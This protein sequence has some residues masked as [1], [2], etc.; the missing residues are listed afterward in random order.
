MDYSEKRKLVMETHKDGKDVKIDGWPKRLDRSTRNSY[1]LI[2]T[3]YSENLFPEFWKLLTI[4]E[5]LV[6]LKR[7][8]EDQT[9]MYVRGIAKFYGFT[10]SHV[11]KVELAYLAKA[12]TYRDRIK[13][14]RKE[15]EVNINTLVNAIKN[16]EK[17]VIKSK[18]F[19]E[20]EKIKSEVK[21]RLPFSELGKIVMHSLD[22]YV[23]DKHKKDKKQG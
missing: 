23:E 3:I 2:K 9:Y 16:L 15:R 11:N 4:D 17:V 1:L 18:D 22:K 20:N 12:E 8:G 10:V 21:F 7:C 6:L 13:E 5:N 14:I 19:W